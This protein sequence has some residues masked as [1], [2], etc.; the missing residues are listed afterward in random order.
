MKKNK[1]PYIIAEIGGNH[2]GNMDLA[3]KMIDIAKECG[4]DAVKFQLYRGNEL[5]TRKHLIELNSGIVKLENVQ[6]WNTKEL[7]LKN[8]FE[9]IEQFAIQEK[10]HIELFEHARK[11]GIDYAS[12]CI[13]NEEIDFLVNQKV[14]FLKIASMDVNNPV[15][16]HHALSKNI[17]IIISLGLASLGE[18]EN[19]VNLIP[20]KY[21][22]N[23]TLLHCISLYPPKDELVNL[24]FIKTLSTNFDIEI[25]YSDHT[26]GFSIALAAVALGAKVIEKHFTLDKNM[27]G[28]DH[29]V[30][31]NPDELKI[32][33]EESKRIFESLGDGR[34]KVSKE[35]MEKRLKFRRSCITATELT[36][37]HI[38]SEKDI[39][40]KRPGTGISPDEIKYLIGR[41]LKKD[42]KADYL[43]TWEDFE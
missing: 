7:G 14:N 28:W 41:K 18:I 36:A 25:G 43:L 11:I 31:A 23:V 29:K 40:Y 34:K 42:V 8:I 1:Y 38:I 5:I 2:N 10:E 15:F 19:V 33:C 26:L 20:E 6:E 12:S 32:I 24:N 27:P 35:E 17:P 9:Q 39:V 4:A 21:K 13:T 22:K 30:S 3:K 16:I 37:S